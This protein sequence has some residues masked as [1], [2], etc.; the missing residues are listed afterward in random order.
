MSAGL[1]VPNAGAGGAL[2]LVIAIGVGLLVGGIA[3][4]ILVIRCRSRNG[5]NDM[6]ATRSGAFAKRLARRRST[7]ALFQRWRQGLSLPQ[8]GLQRLLQQY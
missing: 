1:S 3:V 6:P 5:K 7:L 2:T 8:M 4:T